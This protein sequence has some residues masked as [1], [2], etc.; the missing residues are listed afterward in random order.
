[1]LVDYGLSSTLRWF[2]LQHSKRNNIPVD[3]Q[4]MELSCRLPMETET[5]VFRIAQEALTNATKH[6]Q[7][8]NIRVLLEETD[9]EIRLI[10][11]DDGK[12][13][14]PKSE[15]DSQKRPGWGIRTMRE[16]ATN[17]GGTLVVDSRPGIGTEV[18]LE[19][20]K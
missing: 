16:R 2:I 12:G 6:A 13:F 7:P 5:A 19:V 11:R 8:S 14:D 20:R 4:C 18:R 10:V 1:M 9:T 15:S 3:L 17:A